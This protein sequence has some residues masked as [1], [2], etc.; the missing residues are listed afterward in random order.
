MQETLVQFLGQEDILKKGKPTQPTGLENSM[1]CM[2]H[3][4]Q[5]SDFHISRYRHTIV[6]SY[7]VLWASQMAQWLKNSSAEAGDMDL[8]PRSGRSPGQGNVNLLQSSCLGSPR[9]RG[10]WWATVHGIT[11]EVTCLSD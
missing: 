5:L 10:T 1:N 8:I 9:N 11:K 3:E 7:S 6:I 2:V 4:T